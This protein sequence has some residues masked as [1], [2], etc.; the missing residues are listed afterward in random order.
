MSEG[1][2]PPPPD[3]SEIPPPVPAGTPGPP[4][5]KA[6]QSAIGAGLFIGSSLLCLVLPPFFL[7]GLIG[8]IVS[9][10]FPGYRLIFVGYIGMFGLAL[11]GAVIFCFAYPPKF[12]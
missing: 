1:I 12:D 9:L 7:V 8:A 10:F 2:P 5:N 6:V 11:L 4:L 3:P